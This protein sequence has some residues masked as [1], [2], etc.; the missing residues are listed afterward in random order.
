MNEVMC[1]NCRKVF[2]IDATGYA[3]ILKQV[4]DKQFKEEINIQLEMV[5]KEKNKAIELAE[6]RVRSAL[7]DQLNRKAIEMN[8]LKVEKDSTIKELEKTKKALLSSEN[9]L[10]LANDKAENLTI[11]RLTQGNPTMKAKFEELK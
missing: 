6:E 2:K 8:K 1:P 5:E 3:E 4:R 9:N 10:R 7:Q 11:K